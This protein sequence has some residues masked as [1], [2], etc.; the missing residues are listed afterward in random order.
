[1]QYP[2]YQVS[3]K[4][5]LGNASKSMSPKGLHAIKSVGYLLPYYIA[6]YKGGR[7]SV[8]CMGWIEIPIDMIRI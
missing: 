1:M 3:A 7:R 5:F 8:S 4:Y 2:G 6:N